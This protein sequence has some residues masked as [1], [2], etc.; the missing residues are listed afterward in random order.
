MSKYTVKS[1]RLSIPRSKKILYRRSSSAPSFFAYSR[2][3]G[4][5]KEE[6]KERVQER[7]VWDHNI[8]VKKGGRG[9]EGT[10]KGGRGCRSGKFGTII[11]M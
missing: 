4:V 9:A 5:V 11:P 6:G 2:L 8:R 3:S 1:P 10:K 7:G